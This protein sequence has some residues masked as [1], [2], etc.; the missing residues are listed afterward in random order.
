MRL[1]HLVRYRPKAGPSVHLPGRFGKC[2]QAVPA[3]QPGQK[4]IAISFFFRPKYFLLVLP[5][6][7]MQQKIKE[8]KRCHL[9]NRSLKPNDGLWTTRSPARATLY[10]PVFSISLS[11]KIT[12]FKSGDLIRVPACQGFKLC[13]KRP[14]DHSPAKARIIFQPLNSILPRFDLSLHATGQ[15]V[16]SI[17]AIESRR[18]MNHSMYPF[19]LTCET[20]LHRLEFLQFQSGHLNCRQAFPVFCDALINQIAV[21][22]IKTQNY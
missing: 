15:V 21:W 1:Y 22:A 8:N 2:V 7:A 10:F 3:H 9:I 18:D 20:A 6:F 5:R 12:H 13:C 11:S 4:T 19:P 17:K 16:A 14:Q